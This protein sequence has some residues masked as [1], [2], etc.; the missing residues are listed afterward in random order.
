MKHFGPARI[1]RKNCITLKCNSALAENYNVC[2][3]T[4]QYMSICATHMQILSLIVSYDPYLSVSALA[5]RLLA[6]V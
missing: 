3:L 4:Y 1:E 2:F 5:F 6:I